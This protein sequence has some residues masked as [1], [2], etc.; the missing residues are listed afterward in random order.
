MENMKPLR[1]QLYTM[2]PVWVPI[3]DNSNNMVLGKLQRIAHL[4]SVARPDHWHDVIRPEAGYA[5]LVENLSDFDA[6]TEEQSEVVC[7]FLAEDEMESHALDIAGKNLNSTRTMAISHSG[8]QEDAREILAETIEY[9]Q[10]RDV[11]VVLY[12]PP[13]YEAYTTHFLADGSDIVAGM[14]QA[15]DQLQQDYDVQYYDFSA[16]PDIHTELELFYNSDHVNE[17]G[18]KVFTGRLL[19]AM[20]EGK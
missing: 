7:S 13:Y 8:L 4:M 9:L 12:T 10:E 14:N 17:C 2:L 15:I 19:T 16:D 6:P 20:Q 1:I 5:N 11:E 3:E 18:G